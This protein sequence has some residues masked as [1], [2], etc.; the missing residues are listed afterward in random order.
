MSPEHSWLTLERVVLEALHEGEAWGLDGP[1]DAVLAT[2]AET[3]DF[4]LPGGLKDVVDEFEQTV[5]ALITMLQKPNPTVLPVTAWPISAEARLGLL[6]SG[7][8]TYST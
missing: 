1:G 8:L 3:D 5:A 2:R 6:V 4:D 7:V